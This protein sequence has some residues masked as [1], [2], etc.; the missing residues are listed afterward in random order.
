ME[1]SICTSSVYVDTGCAVKIHRVVSVKWFGV[2]YGHMQI[3]AAGVSRLQTAITV[4]ETLGPNQIATYQASVAAQAP[5]QLLST[6]P[7]G[8]RLHD[9]AQL[10]PDA[11]ILPVKLNLTARLRA[12]GVHADRRLAVTGQPLIDINEDGLFNFADVGNLKRMIPYGYGLSG[13]KG[14]EASRFNTQLKSQSVSKKYSK[15]MYQSTDPTF[16]YA[17]LNVVFLPIEEDRLCVH[18]GV[19]LVILFQKN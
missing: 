6:R 9:F 15:W 8:R 7:A 2:R 18:V 12:Q 10:T 19:S 17:A 13:D 1:L 5:F 11:T 4:F 16:M 14:V 3:L